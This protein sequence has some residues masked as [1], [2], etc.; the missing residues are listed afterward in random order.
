MRM[1]VLASLLCLSVQSAADAYDVVIQGGRVMDPETRAHGPNE[2]LD[3]AV[4]EKAVLANVYLLHEL[5]VTMPT[6]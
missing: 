5:A 6:S 2:S 3:L 4:F 1:W